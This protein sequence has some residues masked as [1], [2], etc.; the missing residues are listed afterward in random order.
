MASESIRSGT[1]TLA[2]RF[3][4]SMVTLTTCAGSARWRRRRPGLRS[5]G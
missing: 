2:M 5:T 4:S 3:S 1:V